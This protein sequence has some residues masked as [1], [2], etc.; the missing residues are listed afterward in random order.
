[1]PLLHYHTSKSVQTTAHKSTNICMS[2][3]LPSCIVQIFGNARR[4]CSQHIQCIHI[5]LRS[6]ISTLTVSQ[7]SVHTVTVENNRNNRTLFLWH[8]ELC[9]TPSW[10]FLSRLSTHAYQQ[11]NQANNTKSDEHEK[12]QYSILENW[13]RCLFHASSLQER[14]TTAC[15]AKSLHD[16]SG[17]IFATWNLWSTWKN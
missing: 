16:A 17:L 2:F 6:G 11:C 14:F 8:W 10:Y 3:M 12:K 7:T 13:P 5:V 15:W 4:S 9:M 1:M